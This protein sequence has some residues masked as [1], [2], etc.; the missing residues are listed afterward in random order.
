[1]MSIMFGIIYLEAE[2][3]QKGALDLIFAITWGMATPSYMAVMI[4][5]VLTD[6]VSLKY[7][8]AHTCSRVDKI[9][10]H[11]SRLCEKRPKTECMAR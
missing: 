7:V 11:R 6:E 1:M 8:L 5:P 4:M 9:R 3:N 2:K 10:I